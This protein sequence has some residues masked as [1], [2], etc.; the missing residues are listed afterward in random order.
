M[1]ASLTPP[2][3]PHTQSSR[4]PCGST[5]PAVESPDRALSFP[6]WPLGPCSQVSHLRQTPCPRLCRI[7][8]A[9]VPYPRQSRRPSG[10]RC[11]NPCRSLPQKRPTTACVQLYPSRKRA[12]ALS[13]LIAHLDFSFRMFGQESDQNHPWSFAKQNL[14]NRFVSKIITQIGN[15]CNFRL[16]LAEKFLIL[17][18]SNICL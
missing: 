16:T 10:R 13:A 5:P 8:A 3:I 4:F 11:Q 12:F 6:L 15:G 1:S 17:F 9:S 18:V 14:S 2:I 7:P